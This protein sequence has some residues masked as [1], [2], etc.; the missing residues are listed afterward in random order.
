M[1]EFFVIALLLFVVVRNVRKD[2]RDG[3]DNGT[4]PVRPPNGNDPF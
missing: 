2:R 3:A 1:F 4:G